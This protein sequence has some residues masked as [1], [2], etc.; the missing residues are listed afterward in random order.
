MTM[1][2]DAACLRV[3]CRRAWLP[4]R[5][6]SVARNELEAWAVESLRPCGSCHAFALSLIPYRRA[7]V[8]CPISAVTIHQDV[9]VERAAGAEVAGPVRR[10]GLASEQARQGEQQSST[11]GA[12]GD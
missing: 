4:R 12:H 8:Y 11:W 2:Q 10:V 9:F 3:W 5:S 1:A 7:P 6:G